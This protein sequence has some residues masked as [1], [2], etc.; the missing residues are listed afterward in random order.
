MEE[1]SHSIQPMRDILDKI[2]SG[3][4][5]LVNKR[6]LV[7]PRTMSVPATYSINVDFT[8]EGGEGA[9]LCCITITCET[10]RMAYGK[11]FRG[12]DLAAAREKALSA[13][14][15]A[16]CACTLGLAS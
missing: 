3:K 10:A 15:E 4:R 7:Q 9:P 5:I 1:L 11:A 14:R 8:F 12:K 16:L 6:G 2:V 13:L